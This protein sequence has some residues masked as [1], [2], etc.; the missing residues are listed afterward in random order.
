MSKLS[1]LYVINGETS[2]FRKFSTKVNVYIVK[3]TKVLKTMYG[4]MMKAAV[5]PV[6]VIR[7]T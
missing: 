2:H 3:P 4:S 5:L 1:V 6:S 7:C